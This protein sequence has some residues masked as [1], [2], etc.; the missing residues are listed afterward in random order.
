[1]ENF[2]AGKTEGHGRKIIFV[3]ISIVVIGM[4]AFGGYYYSKKSGDNIPVVVFSPS[5]EP[6]VNTKIDSDSDGIP[7]VVEQAIKTNPDNMDTDDDSY[8][9]LPEIKGGFSPL[10]AG[11]DGKYT[12]DQWQALKEKIKAADSA[13]YDKNFG[14]NPSSLI[15]SDSDGI[16]DIVE[17]AIGTDPKKL[18]TDGDSF[19]DLAEIK[20]GYS[21]LVAG[22][23]GKLS[24][25][26]FQILKDKIKA[27]DKEFYEREFGILPI[28]SQS[29]SPS[30]VIYGIMSLSDDKKNIIADGKILLSIDND[31]IFDFFRTESDICGDSNIKLM[32]DNK[33]FCE[34]KGIFK[35]KTKFVSIVSSSDKMKAGFT[36]E[37]DVLTPD[38]VIGIFYPYRLVDKIYFLTNYYLGNKFIGFSPM[39]INFAYKGNCWEGYC[40]LYIK[41]SETLADKIDLNNPKEGMDARE[42]DVDF[43]KWIS[44]N[45]IEYKIGTEQKKV[46]F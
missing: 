1:M 36:I 13:F 35:S 8:N 12:L 17:N 30:P 2:D 39:G 11:T 45:E 9:D 5:P 26:D 21:P 19:N 4:L 16:L 38:N 22:S 25:Q 29:P 32:P 3:I 42:A 23:A 31:T 10:I 34:N 6:T 27:A 37:S 33:T 18:D 28:V 46:S 14:N 43:I 24:P 44:D 20:S 41:N 15:D 7:D 40:G